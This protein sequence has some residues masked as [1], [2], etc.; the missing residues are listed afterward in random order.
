MHIDLGVKGAKVILEKKF[1]LGVLYDPEFCADHDG[2]VGF[3]IW[4]R[5]DQVM[6]LF[7]SIF[8]PFRFRI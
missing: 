8:L 1:E 3:S 5:F 2:R 4:N 6:A 7:V